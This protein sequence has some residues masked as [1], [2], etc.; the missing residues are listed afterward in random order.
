MRVE[1]FVLGFLRGL[2]EEAVGRDR[3]AEDGDDGSNVVGVE[4]YSGNKC[5]A[6]DE[7]PG[8]FYHKSGGDV[9][10]QEDGTPFQGNNVS[11]VAGEGFQRGAGNGEGDD[12][13]MG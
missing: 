1:T 12:I 6:G 4:A 11:F 10:E 8:R 13:Q 7:A 5:V 9:G 2:P 3:G